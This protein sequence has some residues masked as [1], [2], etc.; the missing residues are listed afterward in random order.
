MMK[1]RFLLKIR[2]KTKI[3]IPPVFDFVLEVPVNVI[4]QK[5]K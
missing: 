5:K 2:K 1:K 3:S 4:R